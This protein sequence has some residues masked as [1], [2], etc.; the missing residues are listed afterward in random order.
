[1]SRIRNSRSGTGTST[2]S[3]YE[4]AFGETTGARGATRAGHW[5]PLVI[6]GSSSSQTNVIRWPL[7][8]VESQQKDTPSVNRRP[9]EQMRSWGTVGYDHTDSF[10]HVGLNHVAYNNKRLVEP[11]TR[12][13]VSSHLAVTL[14]YLT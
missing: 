12:F 9:K 5:D 4:R 14:S 1:L 11:S 10:A 2:V 13:V 7:H 8:V 3:T 6:E